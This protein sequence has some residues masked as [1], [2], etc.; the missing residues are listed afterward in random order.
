MAASPCW[1][2]PLVVLATSCLLC[3]P[4]VAGRGVA[5]G[6]EEDGA[7]YDGRRRSLVEM[8]QQKAAQLQVDVAVAVEDRNGEKREGEVCNKSMNA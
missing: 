1:F 7:Q 8:E 6:L 2:L 4:V 3:A 5:V